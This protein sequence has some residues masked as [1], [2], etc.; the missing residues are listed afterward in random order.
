MLNSLHKWYNSDKLILLE[1]EYTYICESNNEERSFEITLQKSARSRDPSWR[2]FCK[3][4]YRTS[5]MAHPLPAKIQYISK[6]LLEIVN[7]LDKQISSDR[8]SPD[9]YEIC[10]KFLKM[11]SKVPRVPSCGRIHVVNQERIVLSRPGPR[12]PRTIK[13]AGDREQGRGRARFVASLNAR[14]TRG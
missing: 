12:G 14:S 5:P 3:V 10:L 8:D 2:I 9:A 7:I 13:R 4:E 1:Q 11:D 6:N